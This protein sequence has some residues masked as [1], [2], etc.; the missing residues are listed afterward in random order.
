MRIRLAFMVGAALVCGAPGARAEFDIDKVE[1]SVVRIYVEKTKDGRTYRV[2][3]SGF[4]INADGYVVTNNH[5][6]ESSVWVKIPDGSWSNL[7]SAEIVWRNKFVDLAV[8]KV[9]DFKRPHV[10][11]AVPEPKRGAQV[12]AVGFPGPGDSMERRAGG[13]RSLQATVTA[14][15]VGK[16]F[17]GSHD[18][19]PRSARRMI[20]HS[21][22]T[23]PGN[24]GGPLFNACHQVIGIHTYGKRTILKIAKNPQTGKHFAVGRTSRGIGNGSHVSVLIKY[25]KAEKIAYTPA[26]AVCRLTSAGGGVPISIYLYIAAASVLGGVGVALALR[27]PRERIV[28]VVETYSDM[29]RR[30][31]RDVVRVR[32]PAPPPPPGEVTAG[33]WLFSGFDRDGRSVRFLITERDLERAPDGL[34]IGRKET[35][36]D[37]PITDRSVSRRHARITMLGGEIGIVDLNSTHGTKIDG[38]KLKP[39]A[40]PEA[41]RSGARL[42]LGGVTLKV[43]RQ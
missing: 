23:N 38:R 43:S 5:V 16:L 9:R 42:T 28:K 15:V 24:S 29:L 3:G 41:L 25:L 10:R 1:R 32:Q 39:F 37:R 31:R 2:S 35:L 11:L 20:Q 14:G 30:K 6:V 36:V 12:W 8:I 22:E 34:V 33:G 40:D 27:R 26:T 4:V 18:S 7:R 13:K 19:D 17:L 21:A